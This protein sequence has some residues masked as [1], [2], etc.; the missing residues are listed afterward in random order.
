ML[1]FQAAAKEL[2]KKDSEGK[3]NALQGKVS[4]KELKK[5]V[6][7]IAI[8]E[9][10]Q[11]KPVKDTAESL[12][13]LKIGE[14]EVSG[15][16]FEEKTYDLPDDIEDIDA[17]DNNPLLMSIY[18]KDIYRYLTHLEEIYPIE[19]NYL[20]NQVCMISIFQ[21]LLLLR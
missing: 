20:K 9:I 12:R 21:L 8:K 14:N 18:I 4:S 15:G 16:R 10:K 19:E 13:K 6:K 17:G 2:I 11:K 1:Q 7:L 5:P 3:E